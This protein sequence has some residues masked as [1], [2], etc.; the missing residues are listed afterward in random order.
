MS[1][2]KE[3]TMRYENFKEILETFPHCYYNND[4]SLI[5]TKVPRDIPGYYKLDLTNNQDFRH[6][7][8]GSHYITYSYITDMNG[9]KTIEVFFGDNADEDAYLTKHKHLCGHPQEILQ[10]LEERRI[11]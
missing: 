9:D 11:P 10:S 4:C 3:Y 6:D 1:V 7:I 2:D 5:I 8:S